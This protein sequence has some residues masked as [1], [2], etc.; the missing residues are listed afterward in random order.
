MFHVKQSFYPGSENLVEQQFLLFKKGVQFF[1]LI[2]TDHQFNQFFL[3]IRLLLEWNKKINLFSKND[4]TRLAERHFLESISWMFGNDVIKSPIMDLGSG[5]G[6][7]GV[8]IAILKPDV[9]MVLIES[10]KKKAIFLSEVAKKL[11]LN[12]QI[13]PERVEELAQ[14]ENFRNYFS[15]IISRAVAD[16]STLLEWSFPLLQ[17]G[18]ELLVFKGDSI[19]MEIDRLKKNQSKSLKFDVNI[20]DYTVIK[21]LG[22]NSREEKR[23]LVKVKLM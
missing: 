19:S 6:F 11:K 5:A 10:K 17:Q 16:L 8:P 9:K 1:D 15:C 20:I 14:K 18:G 7:P 4:E 12:I 13:I 22:K 2:L 21:N 23:K 3:Y